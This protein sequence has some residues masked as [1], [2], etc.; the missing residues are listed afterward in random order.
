MTKSACMALCFAAWVSCTSLPQTLGTGVAMAQGA[1]ED[2]APSDRQ[3]AGDLVDR[4]RPLAA[5]AADPNRE[6]GERR[7]LR[8]EAWKLLK[9]AKDIYDTLAKASPDSDP[10]LDADRAACQVLLHA[11]MKLGAV[12]EFE[13]DEAPAELPLPR[14]SASDDSPR[15]STESARSAEPPGQGASQP[16]TQSVL[17]WEDWDRAYQTVFHSQTTT[18]QKLAALREAVAGRVLRYDAKVLDIRPGERGDGGLRLDVCGIYGGRPRRTFIVRPED[19]SEVRLWNK[20][21]R[22]S[23]RVRLNVRSLTDVEFTPIYS[24]VADLAREPDPGVSYPSSDER[25]VG[26]KLY[27]TWIR[28]HAKACTQ[29]RWKRAWS[30][31]KRTTSKVWTVG[32]RVEEIQGNRIRVKLT[33]SVAIRNTSTGSSWGDFG[34]ST[35]LDVADPQVVAAIE[36]GGTVVVAMRISGPDSMLGLYRNGGRFTTTYSFH[37]LE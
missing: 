20:W 22:V 2:E 30:D 24:C 19:A 4:A 26:V 18:V 14:E 27:Q 1:E 12:T 7:R 21:D 36:V 35:W 34:G 5:Q 29:N 17:T 16:P 23:W 8:F 15:T 9:A 28:N 3:R 6:Y 32:A 33:E 31:F 25:L 10:A 37:R 11:V 13:S